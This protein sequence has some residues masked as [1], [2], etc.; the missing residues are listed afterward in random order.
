MVMDSPS[1]FLD[2]ALK[3]SNGNKSFRGASLE[4][5]VL[6]VRMKILHR[7]SAERDPSKRFFHQGLPTPVPKWE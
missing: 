6:A 4:M 5:T 2:Y 3:I 7:R 1:R